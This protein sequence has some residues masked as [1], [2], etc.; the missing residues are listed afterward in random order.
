MKNIPNGTTK[1]TTFSVD[2]ATGAT[3]LPQYREFEKVRREINLHV[4]ERH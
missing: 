4:A 2:R 1:T 3:T